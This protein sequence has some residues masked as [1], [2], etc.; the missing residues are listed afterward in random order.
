MPD[1]QEVYAEYSDEVLLIGVD[2]GAFT[3]LG[4]CEDALALL[5][6][7]GATY[8]YL[9]GLTQPDDVAGAKDMPHL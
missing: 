1:F 8:F 2:V 7:V 5:E 9:P 3:G 6:E 4:A